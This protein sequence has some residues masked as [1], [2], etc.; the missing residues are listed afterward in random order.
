MQLNQLQRKTENKAEKRVGRGGIR[1]KTSG[2]GTKGQRARSGG[3]G[4]L[5]RLGF[6]LILQRIPKKRGFRSFAGPV[7]SVTVRQLEQLFANNETVTLAKLIRRGLAS[8]LDAQA[9]IVGSSELMKK[10]VIDGLLVS[11]GAKAAIE[12]AGGSIVVQKA[13]SQKKK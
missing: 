3:R 4:G 8:R 6:K 9:K 11:A 5:Q 2:R 13:T 1:G 12:K 7:A 10:F